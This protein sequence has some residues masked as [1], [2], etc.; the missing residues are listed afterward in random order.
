VSNP[1][2]PFVSVE[3]R[4]DGVYISVTREQAAK[5]NVRDVITALEQASV[6]N[7]QADQIR[8]VIEHS[9]GG[10]EKIG[11]TFEYYNSN[12]DR[13]IDIKVTP[14]KATIKVNSPALSERVRFTDNVI[15]YCLSTKGIC[16]GVKEE[17]LK[18]FMSEPAYDTELLVAEGIPPIDG[19][20]SE[21][22]FEVSVNPDAKPSVGKGGKVDYR[23]IQTFSSIKQ[24]QVI[25]RRVPPT[26]GQP[27]KAVTGEAIPPVPG[28]DFPLPRGRNTVISEDGQFLVAEKTGIVFE[29]G[30]LINVDELL[31]V[32][33]DVDFSVGN[34][35]YSGNVQIHGGVKAGFIV[36]AEGDIEISGEVESA[37]VISRNGNVVIHHGVIGKN[38]TYIFGKN[39]ISIEFAQN[40]ELRTDGK[41]TVGKSC[42]HCQI[43]C[44]TLEATDGQ[45]SIVGGVVQAY[46][47]IDVI[48][49]GN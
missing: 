3:E 44:N 30:H 35:K 28:K 32:H 45:S 25:A 17:V 5:I 22:Q 43:F 9:R 11:D 15:R 29:E 4:D 8:S 42:L 12:M 46:E 39:G 27:G 2:S 34:V 47:H 7:Y 40:A 20:D 6:I 49:I 38:D 26:E 41:L 48:N 36:E 1:L 19:K 31:Q 33:S 37:R 13:Y 14:L 23:E 10:F 18:K 21:I 16:C 24:G